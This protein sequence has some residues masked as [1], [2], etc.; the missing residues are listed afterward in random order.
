[1]SITSHQISSPSA[2]LRSTVLVRSATWF[3]QSHSHVTL[4]RVQTKEFVFA[5][6][7]LSSYVYRI[8]TGVIALYKHA[9]HPSLVL[10]E[11]LLR[12]IATPHDEMPKFTLAGTE[13][14]TI[15]LVL[16]A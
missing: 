7:D 8:G 4:R 2:A 10:R 9:R 3:E 13:I 12:G 6:G 14:D 5:E 11:P 1:M 16:H 15:V